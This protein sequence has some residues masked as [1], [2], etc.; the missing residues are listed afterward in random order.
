MSEHVYCPTWERCSLCLG[1][2]IAPDYYIDNECECEDCYEKTKD[3]PDCHD[4]T[5]TPKGCL[6]VTDGHQDRGWRCNECLG[7]ARGDVKHGGPHR[8]LDTRYCPE[9]GMTPFRSNFISV[10]QTPEGCLLATDGTKL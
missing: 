4:V 9:C 6:L 7:I 10:W 3:M 2:I 5:K 8:G 1:R